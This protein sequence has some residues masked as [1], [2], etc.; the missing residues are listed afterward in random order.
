MSKDTWFFLR[1]AEQTEATQTE[2]TAQQSLSAAATAQKSTSD[3]GNQLSVEA[4]D[5]VLVNGVDAE[6]GDDGVLVDGVDAEPMMTEYMYSLMMSMPRQVFECSLTML[7]K[8]ERG[9]QRAC[10]A[11]W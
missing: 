2:A 8:G 6:A 5:G 1:Q 10:C 3:D 11:R 4:D 9:G 7:R